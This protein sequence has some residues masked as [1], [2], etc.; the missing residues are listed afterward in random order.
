M[1]RCPSREE[2]QQMLA[3]QLEEALRQ[4]IETHVE[5]CAACQ[6]TL[7]RL[8]EDNGELDALLG[9][10]A[11]TSLPASDGDFVRHLHENPPRG[12]E[13]AS[14]PPDGTEP[15]PIAFPGPPS[16]KGP[17]GQLG[18]FAIRKELS[19]GSFGVVYQA[20]D[21]LDRLV[22]LKILKPELAA[23][24]KERARFGHEARK[25][26][27]VKDD[28][29]VT[30]HQVG[31]TAGFLLPYIVMEHI[32]GEAVSERLRRQGVAEPR[33]AARI[34]HQVAL[35][36]AAAHA[37]GVVHRDIKPSNILLDA[38]SGRAKLTDFGLA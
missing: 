17:L 20:Y 5:A 14:A 21:E 25:A 7:A 9:G 15:P 18:G 19:A 24:A 6:A 4:A 22:A 3:E 33:E 37:R 30:I 27:T 1:S 34:V 38:G 28:H 10:S 13:R 29:I 12:A 16:E 8:S 11:P 31:H 23:S 36:L 32:E 26:A 35:G 2:L